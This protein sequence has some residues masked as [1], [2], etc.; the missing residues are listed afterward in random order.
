MKNTFFGIEIEKY[1]LCLFMAAYFIPNFYATDRIGNQW[2]YLSIISIL[3]FIYILFRQDSKQLITLNISNKG[4]LFFFGFICWCL[5]SIFYSINKVEAIVTFNQYFTV[6]ISFLLFR[7]LTH[8][9]SNPKEFILNLFLWLIIIEMTLSMLPIIQDIENDNLIFRSM[10]YS[11]A[12]A[13]INITAFSL[14]YKVP[15]LLY[16]LKNSKKNHKKFIY[17]LLLFLVMVVISILGTRGAYIGA[18]MCLL[19]FVFYMIISK[20]L[21]RHRLSNFLWV[22]IPI[23]LAVILN[24]SLLNKDGRD[25][26][27]RASTIRL[28]TKDGSV[29][30][31]LRYYKHAITH[32]FDNPLLG[33]G[34]GNWKIKSIDYD[35]KNISGFIV[36]YHAHNDFLQILAELGLLGLTSYLLFL[37]YSTKSLFKKGLFDKYLNIFLLCSFTIFILDSLL[38]FPIARPISQLFLIALLTLISLYEK[39]SSF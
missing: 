18:G 26:I 2:F 14:L 12:A 30:Q 16:F 17:S 29:N 19:M 33:V 34:V 15:I 3:S 11:G 32:F 8:K 20:N 38:N 10:R 21:L 4:V 35:K 22:I 23:I 39:K 27:T 36:P 1:F 5:F 9:I 31:R 25:V 28:D 6:F 24:F 13:N 37:F 7:I